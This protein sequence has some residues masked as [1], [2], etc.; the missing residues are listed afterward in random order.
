MIKNKFEK[1]SGIKPVKETSI[2][3][4]FEKKFLDNL[5]ARVEKYRSSDKSFY[6]LRLLERL[7]FKFPLNPKAYEKIGLCEIDLGDSLGALRSFLT[8]NFLDPKNLDVKAHCAACFL[9][10]GAKD[11]SLKFINE[12]LSVEKHH[13]MGK[14]LLGRYYEI[15]GNYQKALKELQTIENQNDHANFPQLLGLIGVCWMAQQNPQKAFEYLENALSLD[16]ENVDALFHKAV[17]HGQLNEI[18]DALSE[19]EKVIKI[20]PNYPEALAFSALYLFLKGQ[21]NQAVARI[22]KAFEKD[23][24]SETIKTI[25]EEIFSTKTTQVKSLEIF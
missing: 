4:K 2:N 9:M 24:Q 20:D 1:K 12:I 11:K 6:A 25:R 22:E 18:D 13:F 17:C 3:K 14:M 19:I 5:F 7:L 16:P 10:I 8:A 23:P 15:S 21:K